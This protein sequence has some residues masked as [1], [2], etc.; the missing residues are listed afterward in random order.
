MLEEIGRGVSG[1]GERGAGGPGTW[2]RRILQNEGVVLSIVN[3]SRTDSFQRSQLVE[4]RSMREGGLVDGSRR[5][6]G[7]HPPHREVT[8]PRE[9]LEPFLRRGPAEVQ[10]C[11]EAGPGSEGLFAEPV[12]SVLVFLNFLSACCGFL[13]CSFLFSFFP[14]FAVVVFNF[15]VI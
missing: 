4:P 9:G 2:E 5:G 13:F 15:F 1:G 10:R 12:T 6:T 11:P 8:F 14:F 7:G 3:F